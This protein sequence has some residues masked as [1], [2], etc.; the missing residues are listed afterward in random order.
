MVTE[1]GYGFGEW[2]AEKY[3][4][5]QGVYIINDEFDLFF[6]AIL[7]RGLIIHN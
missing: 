6:Q 1:N 7:I 3:F 4:R 2:I 5:S